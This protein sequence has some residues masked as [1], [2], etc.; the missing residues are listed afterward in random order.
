[1]DARA[2]GTRLKP[3]D[4]EQRA[5]LG[6]LFVVPAHF[7]QNLLVRHDASLAVR[8]GFDDHHEAHGPISLLCQSTS[9][10]F[11]AVLPNSRTAGANFDNRRIIYL[12]QPPAVRESVARV[13]AELA[14]PR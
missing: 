5:S 10:S 6:Q 4:R 7:G 2:L 14:P 9:G 8:G 13:P 1:M 12:I 11:A 3:V